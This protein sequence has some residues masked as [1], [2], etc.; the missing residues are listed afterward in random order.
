MQN[1]GG[2][3]QTATVTPTFSPAAG[4]YTTAQTVTLSDS[5]A[6]AT[7]Y[8]TTDASTP[9]TSSTPYTGPITVSS[10]ETIHAMATASGF[11]ASAVGSAAY[12]IVTPLSITTTASQIPGGTVNTAYAGV[13]LAATGGV[14][15]YTW[16]ISSGSLPAGLSL[17]SNTGAISGTPTA[18]GLRS[19]TIQVADAESTPQKATLPASLAISG[20]TLAITTTSLSA[21]TDGSAYTQ[22]LAAS[23]GVPPFTWSV[24]TNPALPAGL[25]LAS[26]TGAISGTPTG[27]SATSPQFTVTDAANNTASASLRL[28]VNPEPG[29]MPTGPYSFLFSG[30]SPKGSVAVAGTFSL[31]G[32][33]NPYTVT[34][35]EFDENTNA[36]TTPAANATPTVI[37]GGTLTNG[38]NGL[39][40][41]VLTAASGNI[42]F[43]LAVP[44][45]IATSGSDSAVRLIEFDD[46]TG[47]GTRGSG[48]MKVAQPN[49]ILPPAGAYAFQVSGTGT[50]TAGHQPQQAITGSFQT[51]ANGNIVSGVAD[52]FEGGTGVDN[53]YTNLHSNSPMSVD[54]R[55][56][57]TLG[58]V[59]QGTSASSYVVY[60]VSP[61]EWFTITL[62]PPSASGLAAGVVLA[63]IGAGSFHFNSLP[64]QSVFHLRGLTQPDLAPDVTM[65][66][67]FALGGT[68][69]FGFDEYN[70]G[71]SNGGASNG[72][73]FDTP[74]TFDRTTGRVVTLFPQT[75]API[76]YLIDSKR[77]FIIGTMIGSNTSASSGML[78]A[79][80]G[81]GLTNSAL[82]GTYLGGSLFLDNTGVL[83]ENGIITADGNGNITF[84]TNRSTPSGP[85]QY[86]SLT[87][88]YNAVGDNGRIEVTLPGG[89]TRIIYIVSPTRIIYLTSDAGGYVGVFEQ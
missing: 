83:N 85:V 14:T 84:T 87:G 47:T 72:G 25:S 61:G 41:L 67:V 4:T 69:D 57:G 75:P 24:G 56:R 88:T 68:L 36:N 71:L 1:N 12:T 6:G 89:L 54:S 5:T 30:T 81:S 64:Y 49:P 76:F 60:Q 79:Q 70:L 50:G 16:S 58:I 37:T 42:T 27:V 23:G 52:G 22:T 26:S 11:T 20:G 8:Y 3:T 45:S 31:S 65:G 63:Q 21:G 44:A 10:S 59:L 9:N 74:Y 35:G 46:T 40:T 77:A 32:S 13:T 53:Q 7:I 19:L 33:G 51:D 62:D 38:T 86:Q 43:A 48:T 82:S 80:T 28:V 17:N 73:V 15:P 78:E 39:G 2:G 34:G 55:G 18:A 29:T 66:L